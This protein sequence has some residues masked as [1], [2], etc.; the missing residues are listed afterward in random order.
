[1]MVEMTNHINIFVKA[2]TTSPVDPMFPVSIALYSKV[3]T[4]TWPIALGPLLPV[5]LYHNCMSYN[6]PRYLI[7]NDV[8]RALQ[9]KVHMSF[10]LTAMLISIL[11][12]VH[13]S[14]TPGFRN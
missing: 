6:T 2:S 5:S 7:D 8:A 11:I 9:Y 1:M 10:F 14:H 4:K 3:K 12:E 13:T